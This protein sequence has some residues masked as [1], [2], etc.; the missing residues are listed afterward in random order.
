MMPADTSL[1]GLAAFTHS[2]LHMEP[3]SHG[4]AFTWSRLH[5][6]PPSHGVTGFCYYLLLLWFESPCSQE[7]PDTR[8]REP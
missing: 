1:F 5:T 3:P 8:T 7:P 4:A 6:E 2:R